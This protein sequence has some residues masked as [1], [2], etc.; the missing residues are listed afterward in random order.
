MKTDPRVRYTRSII[1][2]AF[3]ELLW[4]K[5]VEKITVRELCDRAE[6]NRSTFYKHYRDCYDLLDKMKDEALRQ[7]D[8]MLAGMKA[9]GVK[10]A[11]TEILQKLKDNAAMFRAFRQLGGEHSFTNQLAGRCFAYMDMQISVRPALGWDEAQKGMAYSYLTGGATA[12]I[13]YWLQNNCEESAEQIAETILELSK[14][15][16]AGLSGQ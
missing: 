5:P 6:I 7:F 1:Q 11:M 14:I 15:L 2:S 12:V 3:L 9:R 10:A 8:E 4:Q 16:T 13:E